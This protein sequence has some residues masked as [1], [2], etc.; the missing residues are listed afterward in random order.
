M[1]TYLLWKQKSFMTFVVSH[2]QSN[3]EAS[4]REAEISDWIVKNGGKQQE[5]LKKCYL[6]ISLF[7]GLLRKLKKK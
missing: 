6:F 4:S 5:V 1:R 7:V 3:R 2:N